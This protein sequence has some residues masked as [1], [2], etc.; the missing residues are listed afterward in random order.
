MLPLAK[1]QDFFYYYKPESDDEEDEIEQTEQNDVDV[2]RLLN[3][4]E[5]EDFEAEE[6]EEGR[7]E[8]LHEATGYQQDVEVASGLQGPEV[9]SNARQLRNR[10]NKIRRNNSCSSASSFDE[11]TLE[12]GAAQP[13][14][15]W[16]VVF[17]LVVLG[18]C[19]RQV[20]CCF[21]SKIFHHILFKTKS[22]SIFYLCVY[23]LAQV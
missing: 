1:Q 3:D 12:E 9:E 7:I 10:S 15:N 13:W 4:E 6:E 5:E 19:R 14:L 18:D 22:C 16:S 8:K 23:K 20:F 2:D 11:L 21:N 17:M